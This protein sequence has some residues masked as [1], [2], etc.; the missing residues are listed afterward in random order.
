MKLLCLDVPQPG[1]TLE[2]YAPHLEAEVRHG[3]ELYKN[4]FTR[5]IYF[6]QDR[7]GVAIIAE[8]DSVEAAKAELMNFPLAKAGLIG[9]E[10]L[11][12]GPMLKWELLFA[13]S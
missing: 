10:V 7:L 13:K 12:L 6:R 4:G 11:P 3:W 8:A 9:W 5:D 1:A 2:Q